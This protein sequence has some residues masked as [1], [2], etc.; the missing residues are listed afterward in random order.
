MDYETGKR[1]D[2]IEEL[3]IMIAKKLELF[4]EEEE[5]EKVKK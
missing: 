5:K 3:L 1:L 4:E 2:N